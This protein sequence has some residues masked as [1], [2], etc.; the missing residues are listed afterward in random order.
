MGKSTSALRCLT[1]MRDMSRHEMG[2]NMEHGKQSRQ[3]RK[4]RNENHKREK[5][6]KHKSTYT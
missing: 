1:S 6:L 5:P 2:A 3:Q 4:K